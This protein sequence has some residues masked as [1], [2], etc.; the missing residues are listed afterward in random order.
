MGHSR[1]P[2]RRLLTVSV[3]IVESF[4]IGVELVKAIETG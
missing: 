2:I 4:R 3:R 1:Q